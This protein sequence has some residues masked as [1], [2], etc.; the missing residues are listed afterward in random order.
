M[1]GKSE[2]PGEKSPLNR[3]RASTPGVL[4]ATPERRTRLHTA[5]RKPLYHQRVANGTVRNCLGRFG[6][7]RGLL[8]LAFVSRR[9][10]HADE[11]A[12]SFQPE[13]IQWESNDQ[14]QNGANDHYRFGFPKQGLGELV[15]LRG[16]HAQ[17]LQNSLAFQSLFLWP[18]SLIFNSA[19]LLARSARVP[20]S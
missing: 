17:I 9:T 12:L 15:N 18:D 16:S 5:A 7:D 6:I 20:P 8:R 14:N 2:L 3:S 4:A 11:T 19:F 13:P 1:I 10:N